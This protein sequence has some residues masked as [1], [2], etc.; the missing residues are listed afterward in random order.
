MMLRCVGGN[1]ILFHGYSRNATV[2]YNEIVLPGDSGMNPVHTHEI[3]HD[4]CHMGDMC[5]HQH[6]M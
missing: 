2:S 6:N 1:T 4:V 5:T 3:C